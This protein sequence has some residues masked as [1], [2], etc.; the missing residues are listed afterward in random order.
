MIAVFFYGRNQIAAVKYDYDAQAAE[1]KRL[2][3]EEVTK[4]NEA[5]NR[6][7][8]QLEEN[9]RVLEASLAEN[10]VEYERKLKELEDK[11]QKDIASFV[12]KH[13][14][15]PKAMAKEI[16]TTTGFKIYDPKEKK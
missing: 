7:K 13:G 15:D 4:I 5:R 1:L 14:D 11:K 6:E 9:I 2:H 8:Q 16:S 12:S 3:E 10:K